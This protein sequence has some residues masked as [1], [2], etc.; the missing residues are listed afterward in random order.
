MQTTLT[1]RD[2]ILAHLGVGGLLGGALGALWGVVLLTSFCFYPDDV[3]CTLGGFAFSVMVTAIP[4]VIFCSVPLAVVAA[5]FGPFVLHLIRQPDPVIRAGTW[6]LC[7]VSW[8][9]PNAIGGAILIQ[10]IFD[11]AALP[12]LEVELVLAVSCVIVLWFSASRCAARA[13]AGGILAAAFV[14]ILAHY[15]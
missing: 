10:S 14:L 13:F 9:L 4:G 6:F 8:A 12:I 3:P 15:R 1:K 11:L 5:V 7:G 2:A